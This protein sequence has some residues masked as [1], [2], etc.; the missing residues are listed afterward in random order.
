MYVLLCTCTACACSADRRAK[1]RTDYVCT[2]HTRD[3][4]VTVHMSH[5]CECAL[6]CDSIIPQAT[7]NGTVGITALERLRGRLLILPSTLLSLT[8]SRSVPVEQAC[9]GV[10]K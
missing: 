4:S 6:T 3:K 1:Y 5:I 8:L 10:T 7:A 2:D 9:C